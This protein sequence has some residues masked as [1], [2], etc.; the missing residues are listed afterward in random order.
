M[1][2]VA[3]AECRVLG[4]GRIGHLWRFSTI[5]RIIKFG[6]ARL[7]LR[8]APNSVFGGGC[9]PRQDRLLVPIRGLDDEHRNK[10]Y[11]ASG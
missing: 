8:Y 11:R 2:S 6:S 5:P 9:S 3:D 10:H 7:A 4:N 1:R